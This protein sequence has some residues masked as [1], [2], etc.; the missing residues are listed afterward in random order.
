MDTE[1]PEELFQMME[2]VTYMA[3]ELVPYSL[4]FYLGEVEEYD[5]EDDD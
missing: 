3:N 2:I 1:S 5:S 4:R